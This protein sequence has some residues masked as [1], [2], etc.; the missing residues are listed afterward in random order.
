M[1]CARATARPPGQVVSA[2]IMLS[3]RT[4]LHT[5]ED[6]MSVFSVG[7]GLS[8][9]LGAT[10]RDGGVNFSV[11]SRDATLIELLFFSD[12]DAAHPSRVIPLAPFQHRS[13]HYWH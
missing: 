13:Q 9:P 4:K 3:T 10:I 12:A 6:E 7:K 1:R 5:T 8:A 2:W 11:F